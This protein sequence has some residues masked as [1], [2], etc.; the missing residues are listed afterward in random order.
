MSMHGEESDSQSI[1]NTVLEKEVVKTNQNIIQVIPNHMS[2][3][4]QE[5]SIVGAH[6]TIVR[7]DDLALAVQAV[8]DLKGFHLLLKMTV[9]NDEVDNCWKG[10]STV[11]QEIVSDLMRKFSPCRL[12]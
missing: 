1:K 7:N 4:F 11:N 10:M 8:N 2:F 6:K 12:T 3:V 5:V 9:T